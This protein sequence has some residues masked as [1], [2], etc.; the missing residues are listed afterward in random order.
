[1]SISEVTTLELF[2]L[3]ELL[4]VIPEHVLDVHVVMSLMPL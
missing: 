3:Q 2:T 4:E 1:M